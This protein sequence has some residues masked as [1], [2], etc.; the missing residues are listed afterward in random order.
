TVSPLGLVAKGSVWYLVALI[1]SREGAASAADDIRSYRVSRVQEARIL[2][3][4][5]IYP[6]GFDLRIYW[7]QSAARFKA[8]LP[9]FR[10]KMRARPDIVQR[11]SL[12]GRFARVEEVGKTDEK[13]WVEVSLRFDV[14]EMACEYALGFGPAIEV[15]EPESLRYKVTE[16]ARGVLRIYQPE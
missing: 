8:N 14:E 15:L 10:A 13:G 2:D 12:G 16:A 4:P 5:S 6:A 9:A 11:L 7:E 1:Q 3:E